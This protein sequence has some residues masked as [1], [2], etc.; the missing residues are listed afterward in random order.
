M[1]FTP[2]FSWGLLS[3][4]LLS[5][6]IPLSASLSIREV[7]NRFRDA[8]QNSKCTDRLDIEDEISSWY[9]RLPKFQDEA[10]NRESSDETIN[11]TRIWNNLSA[12]ALE[13]TDDRLTILSLLTGVKPS[14]ICRLHKDAR[15]KSILYAQPQ[16]P[17]ALLFQEH[18]SERLADG[19]YYWLPSQVGNRPLIEHLGWMKHGPT[20][21]NYL[22]FDK[23]LI[24]CGRN[25]PTLFRLITPDSS[26]LRPRSFMLRDHD[27]WCQ[28]DLR[29]LLGPPPSNLFFC[30]S[31]AS[32]L[33]A[34]VPRSPE[35]PGVCLSLTYEPRMER[36]SDGIGRHTMVWHFQYI[37]PMRFS[38]FDQSFDARA[39]ELL[40]YLEC[41]RIDIKHSNCDSPGV[42]PLSRAYV[43]CA[44]GVTRPAGL[45]QGTC[46][47]AMYLVSFSLELS[48][49]PQL[50][51]FVN[52]SILQAELLVRHCPEL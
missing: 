39:M 45:R 29:R 17:L 27:L 42:N 7:T 36:S 34:V 3:R 46:A 9:S 47:P 51:I 18:G 4:D 5:I 11:F 30:T 14:G 41:D 44:N 25:K 32:N 2:Q 35:V 23:G 8:L 40:Q 1:R 52:C 13:K 26:T 20:G 28:I 48:F 22:Y 16:L 19:S 21:S 50:R 37:C 31:Y 43:S 33:S 15:L 49:F 10:K 12:R 6:S 24:D 38:R